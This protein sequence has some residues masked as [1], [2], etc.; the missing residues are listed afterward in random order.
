MIIPNGLVIVGLIGG[1]IV[2]IYNIFRPGE[3]LYGDNSWWTPIAG[4]F[5]ASVLLLLVAVIGMTTYQ[6]EDAIGMGDVKIY[7]PIGLFLGWKL[8]LLSLFISVILGGIAGVILIILRK[9]DRKDAV[10]F[11]PF[12]VFGTFI[13][14]IWGWEIIAWYFGLL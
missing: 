7:A 12:I 11:G 3:F 6:T 10:A 13:S 4:M 14:I 9:K 2:F 1:A 5:S 8:G